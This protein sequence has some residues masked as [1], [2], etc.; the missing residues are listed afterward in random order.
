MKGLCWLVLVPGLAVAQTTQP[1]PG[2]GASADSALVLARRVEHLDTVAMEP[3]PLAWDAAG[4]LYSLWT[5]TAGVWLARSA[6]R[7]ATWTTWHA[8][9]SGQPCYYP[10][11]VARGDGELAATWRCGRAGGVTLHVARIDVDKGGASPQ[12]REA[13]PIPIR[14]VEVR[15]LGEYVALSF[16]RDGALAM[17][18]PAVAGTGGFVWWRFETR[19]R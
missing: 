8:V 14:P 16:L 13:P 12:V 10:Y 2:A 9:E 1:R 5:D 11:L 15:A 17:V 18:T 4:R 7:G 3:K 6:D 19:P